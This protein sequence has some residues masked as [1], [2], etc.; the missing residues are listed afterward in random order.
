MTRC[1]ITLVTS[2]WGEW[3]T[4]VFLRL[5]L[6]S[7]LSP[8]NLPALA[9]THALSYVVFTTDRDRARLDAAPIFRRLQ[10]LV[11]VT[12][13]RIADSEIRHAVQTQ[14]R[15][16]WKA[17]EHVNRLGTHLFFLP[18]DI[19]WSEA[20]MAHIGAAMANG[21]HIVI[22]PWTVRVVSETFQ[23]AIAAFLGSDRG[24]A[25]I[26]SR[27]LVRMTL[28]HL[29]PLIAAY[30]K[31]SP[32]FPRHPEMLV[33]AVHGQGLLL[34]LL[35]SIPTVYKP[36][37]IP[38]NE[39][40]LVVGNFRDDE[41]YVPGDSDEVFVAS[42]A[43]LGKD[44]T[45]IERPRRA[46]PV[47]IG[48]WWLGYPSA[49]NDLLVRTSYRIHDGPIDPQ[50]WRSAERAFDHFLRR[51]VIAREGLEVWRTV[52]KRLECSIA[53]ETIA[54][55][56]QTGAL[57]RTVRGDGARLVLLPVNEAFAAIPVDR[58]DRLMSFEGRFDLVRLMRSH[59]ARF[60]DGRAKEILAGDGG[61]AVL[62]AEDGS[63]LELRR[64]AGGKLAVGGCVI[65]EAP[66]IAGAH[67]ILVTTVLRQPSGGG[68]VRADVSPSRFLSGARVVA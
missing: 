66:I 26:G 67:T 44:F 9:V 49:S 34:R 19:V 14:Q 55:A 65:T 68:S 56:L 15:V 57:A 60:D 50:A 52:R 48:Q 37:A 39:N 43:P 61:T 63:V 8:R 5:N 33:E 31:D 11:S 1:K 64:D 40:K 36:S 47:S 23:P 35:A 59:I 4:D 41:I 17:I 58:L 24:V 22:V 38:L 25:G 62:Q 6:P 3:H 27:D 16:W 53:A 42:L 10:S 21:R 51:C 45:F 7:L 2:V 29:H 54:G 18:P 13:E 28:E 20:S 32:V 46:D 30:K 12:F